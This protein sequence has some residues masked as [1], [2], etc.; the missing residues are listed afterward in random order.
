MGNVSL[1]NSLQ[2][3]QYIFLMFIVFFISTKFPK[4]MREELGG[5]VLMQKI[6]GTILV[7]IGLYMLIIP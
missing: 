6:L 5:G 1:I 2:G 7:T 3:A 4:I